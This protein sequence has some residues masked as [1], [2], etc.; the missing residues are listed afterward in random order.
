MMP[1]GDFHYGC[2]WGGP[3]PCPCHR[4]PYQWPTPAP[5]PQWPVPAQMGWTCPR[6]GKVHA[7]FVPGCDCKP[8]PLEVTA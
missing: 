1:T 2:V 7:P 3:G 8:Q 5:I 4:N 6:C